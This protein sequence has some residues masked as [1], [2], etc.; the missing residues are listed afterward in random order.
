MLMAGFAYASQMASSFCRAQQRAIE[1]GFADDIT[2]YV[3]I[4]GEKTIITDLVT[5]HGC[6]KWPKHETNCLTQIAYFLN[7]IPYG[8]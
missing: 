2:T 4:S 1:M 7:G 3:M 5:G 8:I 6:P